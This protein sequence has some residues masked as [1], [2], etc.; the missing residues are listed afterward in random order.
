MARETF[1]PPEMRLNAENRSIFTSESTDLNCEVRS[2]GAA[3]VSIVYGNK[4]LAHQIL[5]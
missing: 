1:D 4:I 2:F 5:K 3:N